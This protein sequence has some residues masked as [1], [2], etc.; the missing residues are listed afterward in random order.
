MI[1]MVSYHIEIFPI[2]G[3]IIIKK[4]SQNHAKRAWFTLRQYCVLHRFSLATLRDASLSRYQ[5]FVINTSISVEIIYQNRYIRVKAYIYNDI[6]Y[7]LY[8][9]RCEFLKMIPFYIGFAKWN[10]LQ[11]Q[12]PTL[13]RLVLN[14]YT[15]YLH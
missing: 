3:A 7:L 14:I 6:F 4:N 12:S 2:E 8:R 11:N 15:K 13:P 10:P 9:E 1:I 5:Y